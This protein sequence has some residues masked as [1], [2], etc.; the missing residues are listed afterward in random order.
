MGE[1]IDEGC[2]G[3]SSRSVK[4]PAR[5]PRTPPPLHTP[6]HLPLFSGFSGATFFRRTFPPRL[7][8]S[9]AAFLRGSVPPV[10]TAMFAPS[11]RPFDYLRILFLRRSHL[12]SR[13]LTTPLPMLPF[14]APL[15]A[16]S[17][18]SF[19]RYFAP[20]RFTSAALLLRRPFPAPRFSYPATF[21]RRGF[22]PRH[23]SSGARCAVCP[24]ASPI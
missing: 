8:S 17:S 23:L 10:L 14:L 4:I 18:N 7:H 15:L 16:H 19:R 11:P 5:S 24:T 2:A 20:P 12:H 9:A 21:L 3:E 22:P 1:G 6:P 13:T